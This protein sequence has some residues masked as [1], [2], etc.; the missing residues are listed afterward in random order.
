[1][2]EVG[3]KAFLGDIE[4]NYANVFLGDKNSFI[5]PYT[6]GPKVPTNG[7]FAYYDTAIPESYS[8]T[9][10]IWYDIS[11]NARNLQ[12]VSS[13]VFPTFDSQNVAF[14]FN[15]ATNAIISPQFSTSS[16]KDTTEVFWASIPTAKL[17]TDAGVLGGYQNRIGGGLSGEWDAVSY[18]NQGTGWTLA[19]S[20]AFRPVS[21]NYQEA[22]SNFVLIVGTRTTNDFKIYRNG[23]NVIGSST[24]FTPP[25]ITS[26]FV[27]VGDSFLQNQGG[28]QGAFWGDGWFTGS[29]SMYAL[30]DRVLSTSEIQAIYDAGRL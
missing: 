11:G 19:S 29:I 4:V 23:N 30:Y 9:G 17:N 24:S 13:S 15:Q 28:G 26:G 1:M 20:N 25:T 7:L 3:T 5:N 21:S 27:Y 12:T 2:S 16:L 10:T 8:G 14:K 6:R 22:N 18:G